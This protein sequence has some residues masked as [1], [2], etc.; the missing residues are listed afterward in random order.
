MRPW[1]AF[2]SSD[3]GVTQGKKHS[4]PQAFFLGGDGEMRKVKVEMTGF[5]KTRG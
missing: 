4:A 3:S 2:G 5:V 1:V